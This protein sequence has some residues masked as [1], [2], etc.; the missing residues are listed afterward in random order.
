MGTPFLLGALFLIHPDGRG[1]LDGLLPVGE[2]WLFLHVAILPLLG[3]LG[4]SFYVLLDDY[5]GPVATA[6]RV[7]V[8]IYMTFYIAFE[9][10][11]GIATGLISHEA[12]TLPAEQQAGVAAV[13]EALAAPAMLLG[14]VGSL[15]AVIATVAVG[16][17]MR[18]SG[19]P[20]AAVV[21]LAG[22]PFATV[23]HAGTPLDGF[24]MGVF[25]VG[26]TWLEIGWRQ[27]G[28]QHT[29]AGTAD[30]AGRSVDT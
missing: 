21:L 22:A 30:D 18:R 6:G 5:A 1:G 2:T 7:G 17:L 15:G 9:A 14:I 16:I 28:E 3:L 12:Q 25:L 23:F 13:V 4:V 26:I 27:S 20:L 10:I 29:A 8:A 11:L 19:A 24:S